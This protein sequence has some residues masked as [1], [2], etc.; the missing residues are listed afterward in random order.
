[1][2]QTQ[3]METT[4]HPDERRERMEY[5]EMQAR[6]ERTAIKG[7]SSNIYK[8]GE[9]CADGLQKLTALL[10]ELEHDL[11]PILTPERA[12]LNE[13]GVEIASPSDYSEIAMRTN[14]IGAG[15][16]DVLLRVERLRLR[17]D[18]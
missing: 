5:A 10:N 16:E 8:A 3:N 14:A 6:A 15:I 11:A 7:K 1:M 9:R 18:L 12:R 4:M 17:I 13:E 2:K